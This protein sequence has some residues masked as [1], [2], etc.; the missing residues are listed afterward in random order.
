M[1]QLY[2]KRVSRALEQSW[3]RTSSSKWT[4][5]NPV[6]GQCG[7]TVLVV[8]DSFGGDIVKPGL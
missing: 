1:Q 8:Q 6:Y 4:K 3:S 2:I 7:V 5:T